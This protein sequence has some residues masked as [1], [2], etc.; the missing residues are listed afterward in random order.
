MRFAINTLK[1]KLYQ[2]NK[3]YAKF[4]YFGILSEEDTAAKTNR[5]HAQELQNAIAELEKKNINLN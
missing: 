1:K 5:K 4:V 3:I 2:L